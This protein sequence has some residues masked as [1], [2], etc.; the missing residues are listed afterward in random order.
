MKTVM[1]SRQKIVDSNPSSLT[2]PL[3]KSSSMVISIYFKMCP[4]ALIMYFL[5][6]YIKIDYLLHMDPRHINKFY[7]YLFGDLSN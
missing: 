6:C 1:P 4:N 2:L 5:A 7:Q 3:Y